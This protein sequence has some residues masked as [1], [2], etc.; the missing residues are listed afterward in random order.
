MSLTQA[1]HHVLEAKLVV[2]REPP[3]KPNTSSPHYKH[4][5]ICMYHPNIRGHDTD[6]CLVLKNKIQ[7]LIDEGVLEFTQDGQTEFFYHPSKGHH[8]KWQ[9]QTERLSCSLEFSNYIFFWLFE[10]LFMSNFVIL[11]MHC[12]CFS[13]INPLVFI[14]LKL[15]F[16]FLFVIFDSRLKAISL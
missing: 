3:Q 1:L 13:W 16:Y 7:D 15:C 2:L 5:E 9:V 12:I 11:L 14:I 6:H 4:N 8:Q 10:H